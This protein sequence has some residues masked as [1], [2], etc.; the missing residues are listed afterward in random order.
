MQG[1]RRRSPTSCNKCLTPPPVSSVTRGS[2]TAVCPHYSTMSFTGWTCQKELCTSWLSWCIVVCMVKHLGTSPTIS[3]HAAS[4]V[5][6]PGAVSVPRTDNNFSY[7]AVD[8]TR[9]A[10]GLSRSLVRLSGT[11]YLTNL[12]IRRE[13]LTVLNSSLRQSCSV[14]TN[15]N[16]MRYINSHLT[17]L[18]TY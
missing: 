10:V 9:T 18:L 11:H 15:L 7:L 17:Y 8:S 3:L 14:F 6:I 4:D 13:V 16:D 12:K 2:L 1:R 5:A